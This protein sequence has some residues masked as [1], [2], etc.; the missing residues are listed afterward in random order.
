MD[1][2]EHSRVR[3]VVSAQLNKARGTYDGQIV[4]DLGGHQIMLRQGPVSCTISR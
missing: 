4:L 1:Q 2:D 3:I